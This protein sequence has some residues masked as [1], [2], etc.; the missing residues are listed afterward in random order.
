MKK[1]IF[2]LLVAISPLMATAG[3][4]W[5]LVLMVPM[6]PATFY[7]LYRWR[8][9]RRKNLEFARSGQWVCEPPPGFEKYPARPA[10]RAPVGVEPADGLVPA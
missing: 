8:H 9:I 4:V 7:L 5:C 1:L 2:W 6:S 10:H 3:F